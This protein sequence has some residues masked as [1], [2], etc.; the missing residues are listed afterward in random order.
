MSELEIIQ[1]RRAEIES[2][3]KSNDDTY[4]RM[5]NKIRMRLGIYLGYER[6]NFSI[7][8]GIMNEIMGD[9]LDGTRTW[10]M[11]KSTIEQ[12]LWSNINSEV[13]NFARKEKKYVFIPSAEYADNDNNIRGMDL[14]INCPPVDIE[15]EIDAKAIEAFC[16]DKIFKDDDDAQIILD[17][18]MKCKKQKEIADYLGI[19]VKK[20]E[21]KI[22]SIRSK[23][24]MQLPPYLLENIPVDLK[25]K[26]RN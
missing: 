20:M 7:E 8:I 9:I 25:N 5:L 4:L 22:R 2:F 16:F 17:E 19:P 3:L 26:I 11:E 1:S 18:M 14:L 24:R 12:V 10:D 13:F 15:G 21:M 23:I 6:T